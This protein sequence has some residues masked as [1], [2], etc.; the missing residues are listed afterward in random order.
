MAKGQKIKYFWTGTADDLYDCGVRLDEPFEY[1]LSG[2]PVWIVSGEEKNFWTGKL[3]L[4]K[5]VSCVHADDLYEEYLSGMFLP[6]KH[7]KPMEKRFLG[8]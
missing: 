5:L 7:L 1:L 3:K 4:A 8:G 6:R 2:G